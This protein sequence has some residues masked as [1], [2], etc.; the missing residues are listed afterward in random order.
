MC[1][2]LS[3][4]RL[5]VKTCEILGFHAGVNEIFALLRC[6]ETLIDSYFPMLRDTLSPLRNIPEEQ[7][8]QVISCSQVRAS[9]YGLDKLTN[10][11]QQFHKFIT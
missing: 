8:F 1:G 2:L 9:S 6:Y 3:L 4:C 11:M 5:Q 7:R 10:K